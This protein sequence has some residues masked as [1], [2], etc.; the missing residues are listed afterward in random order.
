MHNKNFSPLLLKK[1]KNYTMG[2]SAAAPAVVVAPGLELE[3]EQVGGCC[4]APTT[5]A[6]GRFAVAAAAGSTPPGWASTFLLHVVPRVGLLLGVVQM[7]PARGSFVPLTAV[8]EQQQPPSGNEPAATGVEP[9]LVLE[10]VELAS[11]AKKQ[12]NY[13]V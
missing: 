6:A 2:S 12:T 3:V 4:R 5:R 9:V 11:V 13:K 8:A 1:L 7:V 10:G